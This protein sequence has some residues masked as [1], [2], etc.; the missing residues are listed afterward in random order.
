MAGAVSRARGAIV[1]GGS[2]GLGLEMAFALARSGVSVLAAA[3]IEDDFAACRARA[4]A[5]GLD[6][7]LFWQLA[8]LRSA[9]DCALIVERAQAQCGQTDILVNNAGLTL[10]FVAPDLYTRTTPRRFYESS[11][12]ILQAVYA[13]NV[14]APEMLAAKVAPDMVTRGWGRIIN[15]TTMLSTME[16]SGFAPY[17]SS[18]AALEMASSVWAADLKDTGVT[19]N[20]L[21]PGGGANTLGI[22][23]QMRQASSEGRVPRLVEAHE[24]VPPLLWLTS[25][26]A[27]GVNGWR[28][29]ANLWDSAMP[30][31]EAAQAAGRPAGFLLKD[32]AA[33]SSALSTSLPA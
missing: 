20:I 1:T 25:D 18:K 29:D 13:T 8:D 3:H 17:G 32:K 26:A 14:V 30:A 27:D 33:L 24:M 31:A 28:F 10:T 23:A 11:D 22:A 19:V 2:R 21:N 16:R 15:V 7:K 4:K 9:A 5:E 12:T 6:D